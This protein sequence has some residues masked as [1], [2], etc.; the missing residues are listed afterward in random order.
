MQPKHLWYTRRDNEIRGPFPA[1][2]ITRH[3]LLGRVR[4]ED[5]LSTDRETWRRADSV[6]E[7]MPDAMRPG[8]DEGARVARVFAA[9]RWE[10]ERRGL[11]RRTL[12]SAALEK[13][14][15]DKRSGIER[16]DVEPGEQVHHR[17]LSYHAHKRLSPQRERQF[18]QVLLVLAL[19][20]IVGVLMYLLPRGEVPTQVICI[21]PPQPQVNWNNCALEGMQLAGQDLS[22]G[23]LRNTRLTGANLR[24]AK[25]A[26][27]D[28]AYSNLSLANL[29]YANLERATLTGA[30]LRNADLSSANLQGADLSY[31][32]LSGANLGGAEI[33]NAKFDRAIWFDGSVC[34]AGSLGQ[35]LI[36]PTL[37]AS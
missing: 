1:G 26:G 17:L 22:N 24:G 36:A 31:A 3:L 19:A 10:D 7:L 2:L 32:D 12:Q 29:S 6:W 27:S 8:V 16:R 14:H 4:G 15:R 28:L 13:L 33:A 35:C 21:A 18:R 5:E 20:C 37:P 25:L 11:D 23:K 30:D 9:R 34:A